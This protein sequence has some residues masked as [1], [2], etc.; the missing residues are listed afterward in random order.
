MLIKGICIYK[1]NMYTQNR[2]PEEKQVFNETWAQEHMP[3]TLTEYGEFCF[4]I[5]GMLWRFYVTL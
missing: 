5:G 1:Y 2:N 3:M 4:Q